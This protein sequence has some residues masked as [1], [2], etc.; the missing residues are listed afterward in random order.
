MG[1]QNVTS[2]LEVLVTVAWVHAILGQR[3]QEWDLFCLRPS[4]STER[5]LQKAVQVLQ[6]NSDAEGDRITPGGAYFS[7]N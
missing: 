7:N 5:Y 2:Y 4:V 3:R 1:T 6:S